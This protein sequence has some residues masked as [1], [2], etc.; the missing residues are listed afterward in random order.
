MVRGSAPWIRLEENSASNKRLD[1]WVDPTSS[2]GYIGANQSAQ[3]L[4]FQTASSDRIRILN[5][6]N[7]GIGTTSPRTKLEIGGS[8]SLGAVTNKVISAT[9]DGGYSTTTL[10][11]IT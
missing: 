11:N 9:F 10:Y 8:G 2:I 6:G 7:V 3:Q 5:N 1:L 4:S